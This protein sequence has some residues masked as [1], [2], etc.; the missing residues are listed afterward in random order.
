MIPPTGKPRLKIR[1]ATVN[2]AEVLARHRAGMFRD[3]GELPPD[4]EEKLIQTSIAYFEE[5][6]PRGE[7]V[8]WL[9]TVDG[10]HGASAGANAREI[11]AGAG[12]QLR[13][14]LPRPG[15]SAISLGPEAVVLNVFTEAAWRRRGLAMKLMRHVLSWARERGIERIVLHASSTGR[16]LYERLGFVSTNEMRYLGADLLVP[17]ISQPST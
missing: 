7:Y 1:S 11:V 12:V 6:I 5:A 16:P 2:D 10:R 13:R 17:I 4:M 9:V 8:G 15:A 14:I 3:M